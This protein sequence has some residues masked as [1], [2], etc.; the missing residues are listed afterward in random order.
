MKKLLSACLLAF[1]VC[2][3][4]GCPIGLDYPLGV[5]GTEKIDAKLIGTWTCEVADAEVVTVKFA[6]KDEYTYNVDVLERGELYSLGTDHLEGWVTS[7]SGGTF[8][9]LKPDDESKYYHYVYRIEQGKL[10]VSDVSLLDG[11]VDAVT[12]TGTLRSQVE[13]SMSMETWAN[14][15]LTYT[16]Q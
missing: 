14:E 15:S 12:S 5:T 13:R 3:F 11:G 6:K 10:I 7:L 1:I 16:K 4:Y 8:L 2:A 9:F